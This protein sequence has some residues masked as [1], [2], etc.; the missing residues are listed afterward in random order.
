MN[1]HSTFAPSRAARWTQCPAEQ[2][3]H[4]RHLDAQALHERARWL[5]WVAFGYA[6]LQHAPFTP[7]HAAS[8]A[9]R[10]LRFSQEH[11]S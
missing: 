6:T 1:T 10:T 11:K 2:A 3:A 7:Y 4:I 8:K 9:R 5:N